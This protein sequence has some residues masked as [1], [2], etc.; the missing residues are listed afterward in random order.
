[1]TAKDIL[2]LA[3]SQ[4]GT[5]ASNVKRCKYNTWFYGSDVSGSG[6]DWCAGL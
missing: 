4:I 5:I 1:M 3:R 2:D 6:Y